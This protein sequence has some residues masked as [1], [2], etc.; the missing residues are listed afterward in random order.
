MAIRDGRDPLSHGESIFVRAAWAFWNGE[1][2]LKLA[3]LIETLD[4]DHAEAI[5]TLVVAAKRGGRA[6]DAWLERYGRRELAPRPTQRGI[7]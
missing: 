3:E 7:A 6:V 2:G 5:C 4:A 1:G